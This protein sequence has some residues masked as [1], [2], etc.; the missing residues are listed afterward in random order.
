VLDRFTLTHQQLAYFHAFGFLK[1]DGLFLDRIDEISDA[2]DTLFAS[3]PAGAQLGDLAEAEFTENFAEHDRIDTYQH[4][5]FGR[6]RAIIPGFIE[7]SE[8]LAGLSTDP[9]VCGAVQSILGPDAEYVGGDGNVFSCDTAW[10]S[11]VY[12]SP[13]DQNHV[14]VFFYLDELT[15]ANGALRVI[16]GSNHVESPFTAQ[17]W[18]ELGEWKAIPDRLGIGWDEVPCH[19][20][21]NR[22]GDVILG[23]FR[24]FHATVN[25]S[26]H[27]RLFTLNFRQ[28]A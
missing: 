5:N 11:D 19:V 18:Q 26:D 16:P 24:T 21:T 2:F 20:V 8:C 23:D 28:P 12:G 13:A 7:R 14:K 15:G 25:S 3:I 27:R 17:L 9:R 10:H 1:L 6:Q 4:L 22:P